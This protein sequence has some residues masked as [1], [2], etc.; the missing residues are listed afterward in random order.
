MPVLPIVAALLTLAAP[1]GA[2]PA[3]HIF[4]DISASRVYAVEDDRIVKELVTNPGAGI[5][6]TKPGEFS[7]SEKVK[8]GKRSN[9]F[10]IH[11]KPMTKET[12]P[13]RGAPMPLWMRLGRTGQGFHRSSLWSASGRPASHG[14]LRLS[15]RG[16]QWL[17]AWAPKGTPV[18]VVEKA[19]GEPVLAAL[20]QQKALARVANAMDKASTYPAKGSGVVAIVGPKR[21]SAKM[22]RA[23]HKPG[24]SP[25]VKPV[26]KP[27]TPPAPA[28][29]PTSSEPPAAPPQ[30]APG[31]DSQQAPPL[32][33]QAL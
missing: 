16:A 8:Q 29:P 26:A 2:S 13:E 3:K 10:D 19:V 25:G 5:Y 32:T 31:T 33:P 4:V 27:Q 12:D 30:P 17:F 7:I 28:T 22:A 15:R 21:G 9:L 11:N 20:V 14:C 24:T 18:T 6:R 23:N 1:V